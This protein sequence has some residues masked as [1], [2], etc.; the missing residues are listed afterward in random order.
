MKKISRTIS[1]VT[2]VAVMAKPFPCPG[3]CVYCPSSP[4]APKSYTIESPAV[5]RAR[6]CDFDAKR[7]VESRFRTLADMG[8]P[9]DKIELI[10][11]GGTF[12]AY[13]CEYQY[14]FVKDCYDAL[15]G[16]PSANLEEAKKMN[17]TAEHRCVGLCIE[18]RPDWCGEVEIK[19]MLDFG[20]TRVELGAQTLDDDIHRLTKRG[21]GV[22]EVISATRLLRDYG[23]KVYYHWMP[24]L[25]GST[26][27]HDLELSRK[28]FAEEYFRPDGLKLYP[29]LVVVGSELEEWYR[30]NRYQP[31]DTEVMIDLLV[32]I[33]TLIPKYVRIPRLMRDIPS[34]FIIAGSRDLALRG[35]VRK[36]M[37]EL[38]LHCR[39]IRCREY[40]H[41]LRDGWMIGEPWLF[42]MD[43]ET[44]A[45]KEIFL[46]YED[47]NE[48]LFGLLRLRVNSELSPLKG[49]GGVRVRE[50][51]VFGSE[52]PLGEKRERAAQHRGLGEKLLRQAER[53]AQEEF[54]IDKLS[55]L[56]GVGSR[57]Y[58]R[59]LGYRLESAYMVKE[60]QPRPVGLKTDSDNV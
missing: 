25:P 18:T 5:L 44:Y 55:I 1:G 41:R 14:Q 7:Q 37:N 52:V 56:S 12:L 45:G 6:K 30:D 51:H 59:S 31:Y 38:G 9:V 23:F 49:E 43:Y 47:A 34:K 8:H 36:R 20:T 16:V 3:R 60:L 10:I 17:E 11:M 13:P 46:S 33:K 53:I 27:E 19:S 35:S 26:P 29:T 24:G 32:N 54:H 58:F 40:G 48:T 15:N 57:D 22:A 39:C 50:L 21:H 4:E 2:P 28:L 42:R